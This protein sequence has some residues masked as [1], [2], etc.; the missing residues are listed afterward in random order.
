[1]RVRFTH[2]TGSM[3]GSVEEFSLPVIKVGRAISSDLLLQDEQ[4]LHRLASRMHAEFH[5]NDGNFTIYDLSSR[6]GTFVNGEPVSEKVLSEGDQVSFGLNGISFQ[7]NFVESLD[8]EIEF[9]RTTPIFRELS[10][11]LLQRVF[12]RGQIESYPA[13]STLF[14]VGEPSSK[15]YVIR[16][17]IVELRSPKEDGKQ[18]AVNYIGPGQALGETTALIGE[19]HISEARVPEGAEIFQISAEKLKEMVRSNP[20]FAEH[21]V[22]TFAKYL[23]RSY[24]KLSLQTKNKLQGS[25]FYFD[26][27][28][29]IQTLINSK[30]SGLLTIYSV[31]RG[32]IR[33][34]AWSTSVGA[35]PIGQ[36]YLQEG[37]VR[38]AW[39]GQ[40]SGEEAFYQLFQVE[41]NGSFSF[42]Q[43]VGMESRPE[44]EMIWRPSMNLVME[45]VRLQDELNKLRDML[46]EQTTAFELNRPTLNVSNLNLSLAVDA[47]YRL[48]LERPVS[49]IELV[50]ALPCCYYTT[51]FL[52]K[53]FL[54]TNQIREV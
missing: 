54:D 31:G 11:E 7:V 17:G 4:G 14:R 13:S 29:V 41:L 50:D 3:R 21:M 8:E 2:L 30:E 52:I 36:V 32:L 25:L 47:M 27:A 26:L 46:P 53:E 40:L 48:L 34:M 43:G 22:I 42:E 5:L 18:I 44:G 19:P 28:T 37:Q 23:N 9:L 16:N 24:K 35:Y 6:N 39:S 20:D 33:S 49:I 1:M 10:L 51:Y 15:L 45:A 38:Y 12:R